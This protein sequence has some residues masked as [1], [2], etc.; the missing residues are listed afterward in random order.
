MADDWGKCW[1]MRVD[2]AS[3]FIIVLKKSVGGFSQLAWQL[4][5][6]YTLFSLFNMHATD[7]SCRA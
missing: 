1:A 3:I 4:H 7:L 5:I 6:I 2:A